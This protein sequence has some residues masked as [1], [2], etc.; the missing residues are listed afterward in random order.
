[1][2]PPVH[3]LCHPAPD[4]HI[5]GAANFR[6]QAR[7]PTSPRRAMR[8]WIALAEAIAARGAEVVV[9]SPPKGETLTGMMYAAN[10]GRYFPATGRF[11]VSRMHVS[12]R[13][14]E[15]PHVTRFVEEVLG[16]KTAQAPVVWEGQADVADLPGDRHVLTYG[17]R[18][19]REASELVRAELGPE[20][21]T[22][23]VRLRDPYFHGDTCL[24]ALSTPGGKTLLLVYPGALVDAT[25]EDLAAFGGE[26]VE[27][28]TISEADAL[29]YACN[30][31]EVAG[32]LLVPAG[33]SDG[34]LAEIE[35]H[36][37]GIEVMDFGE[38][39]GKGGGGPRCLVNVLRGL[40][41][42][43]IPEA[44]RF[45]VRRAE[46]LELAETFPDSV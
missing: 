30:A 28:L 36:G 14:G 17:V 6:S 33:V 46:L 43:R 15:A 37:L 3:L 40:P 45:S 41:P 13:R 18:T 35:G 10:F 2:T 29:A 26:A 21:R 20:A 42:E 27:V 25:P 32:T 34:L 11:V 22:L 12:H 4:W 9:L 19:V 8:E 16:L 1:M 23:E 39:F 31:L 38:L 24:S 5:R 7:A 44:A